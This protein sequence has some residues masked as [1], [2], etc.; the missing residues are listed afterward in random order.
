MTSFC[1]E[2]KIIPDHFTVP[3]SFS[4]KFCSPFKKTRSAVN[5]G[6]IQ[7]QLNFLKSPSNNPDVSKWVCMCCV[8]IERIHTIICRANGTKPRTNRLNF[9]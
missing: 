4:I 1:D 8:N 3:V 5:A 9:G 6:F 2:I 7:Q